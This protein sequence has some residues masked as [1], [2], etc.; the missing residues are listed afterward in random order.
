M[1]SAPSWQEVYAEDGSMYYFN[2]ATGEVSWERGG[3]KIE[4][5][6]V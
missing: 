1:P 5:A 2:E 4:S 6:F 3:T